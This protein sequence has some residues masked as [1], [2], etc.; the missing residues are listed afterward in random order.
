MN[1]QIIKLTKNTIYSR[2]FI[3]FLICLLPYLIAFGYLF[4]AASSFI[5]YISCISIIFL[6]SFIAYKVAF[7]DFDIWIDV[8]KQVVL[9]KRRNAVEFVPVKEFMA[10]KLVYMGLYISY[11]FKY[12]TMELNG[13]KYRIR[14]YSDTFKYPNPSLAI[15]LNDA[16]ALENEI[17]LKIKSLCPDLYLNRINSSTK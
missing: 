16:E 3:V 9:I 6:F 4:S 5:E 10:F 11:N 1:Y 13:K 15:S 8:D 7:N 14:Y 12:Y 17:K 2:I